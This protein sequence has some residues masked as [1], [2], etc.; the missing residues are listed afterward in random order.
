MA[1][2]GGRNTCAAISKRITGLSLVPPREAPSSR[3][4]G[5]ASPARRQRKPLP[6]A[7]AAGRPPQPSAAVLPADG[8]PPPAAPAPLPQLQR[9][10]L[11]ALGN[12]MLLLACVGRGAPPSL[13]YL[14]AYF[15]REFCHVVAG[16]LASLEGEGGDRA[17]RPGRLPPPVCC[18]D[19][20]CWG[21]LL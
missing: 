17:R 13:E 2:C 9:E 15:S 19:R 16:L 6:G 4:P 5:G 3:C 20:G 11:A 1:V 18:L 8:P 14:T 12:L 10:D 7:G 21:E